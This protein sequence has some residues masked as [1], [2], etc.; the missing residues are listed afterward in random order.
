MTLQATDTRNQSYHQL[1]NLG[2]K[3][4]T[5][6]AVIETD[7]PIC[8]RRIARLLGWD[9]NC[10]TPR[11][12]ELRAKGLVEKA[13]EEWDEATERKVAT[14]RVSQSQLTVDPQGQA[15]LSL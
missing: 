13:G 12:L 8:N 1:R 5:V 2:A 15:V 6:L 7:G 10:V 9:V 14:W 4:A 3:Q 11:C